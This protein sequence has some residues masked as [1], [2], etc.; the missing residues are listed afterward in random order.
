MSVNTKIDLSGP[1]HVLPLTPG[2]A[3]CMSDTLR[4]SSS[5]NFTKDTFSLYFLV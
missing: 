5:D 4:K 3:A 1:M 2:I